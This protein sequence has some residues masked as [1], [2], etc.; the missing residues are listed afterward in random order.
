ME[1][2]LLEAKVTEEVEK[3]IVINVWKMI[4]KQDIEVYSKQY[5]VSLL[6][7]RLFDYLIYNREGVELN[8]VS[9]NYDKIAEYAV[10]Q[11]E[12]YLNTGFASNYLGQLKVNLD[13]CPTRLKESYTGKVNIWKVHGSLDWF[14]KDNVTY[15]F[16]NMLE[17]P[18]GYTLA[19]LLLAITNMKNAAIAS[20]RIVKQGR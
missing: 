9:T 14:K 6:I 12:A 4:V 3:D 20:S 18:A 8:V 2:A 11:S 5:L 10:S 17:I 16:P 13:G 1:D 19:L 15:C 7:E